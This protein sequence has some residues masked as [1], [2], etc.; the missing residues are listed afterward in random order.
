MNEVTEISSISIVV[1]SATDEDTHYTVLANKHRVTCTCPDYMYR[2]AEK[3]GKC[4]HIEFCLKQNKFSI[5]GI[6]QG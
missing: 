2:Q 1:P 6:V 4:K 3:G 5:S